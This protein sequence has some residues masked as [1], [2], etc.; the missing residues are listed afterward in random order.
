M[1]SK[2]KFFLSAGALQACGIKIPIAIKLVIKLVQ[3]NMLVQPYHVSLSLCTY[4]GISMLLT[5]YRRKNFCM[6]KILRNA[7]SSIVIYMEHRLHQKH[8]YT[9]YIYIHVY[10][11]MSLRCDQVGTPGASLFFLQNGGGGWGGGGGGGGGVHVHATFTYK[12]K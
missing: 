7:R 11:M 2:T 4:I 3:P 9:M 12:T 8:I 6:K 1:Y 10:Q 5:L